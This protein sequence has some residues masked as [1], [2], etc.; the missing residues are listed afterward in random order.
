MISLKFRMVMESEGET[1]GWNEDVHTGGFK[2]LAMV[3]TQS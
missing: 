1:V 3:E 2:G